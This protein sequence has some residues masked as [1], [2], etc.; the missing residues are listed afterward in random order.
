MMKISKMGNN[1]TKLE[2]EGKTIYFSYETPMVAKVGR[3][4]YINDRFYSKTTSRHVSLFLVDAGAEG[5]ASKKVSI[6][7]ME[8]IIA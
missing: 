8:Q 5:D 1:M 7:E 3:M 4:V 2:Q 6:N